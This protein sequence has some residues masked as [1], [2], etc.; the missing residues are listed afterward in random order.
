MKTILGRL[1]GSSMLLIT[2]ALAAATV[3]PVQV[4]AGRPDAARFWLA[5]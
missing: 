2:A 1:S 4:M 5:Q 3:P